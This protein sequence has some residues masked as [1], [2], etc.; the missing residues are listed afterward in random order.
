VNHRA[1]DT[2][3]RPYIL[4]FRLEGE[5]ECES[6]KRYGVE[7]PKARLIQAGRDYAR[8]MEMGRGAIEF[9]REGEERARFSEPYP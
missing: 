5:A 2:L 9:W 3:F 8:V 4:C 6:I 1:T 7:P